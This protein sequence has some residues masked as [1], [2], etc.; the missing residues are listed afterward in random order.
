[1]SPLTGLVDESQIKPSDTKLVQGGKSKRAGLIVSTGTE[2]SLKH[3]RE[4]QSSW[5]NM[6]KT[7]N[8][9]F[10]VDSITLM[11]KRQFAELVLIDDF[12]AFQAQKLDVAIVVDVYVKEAI[13][14]VVDLRVLLFD[15]GIRLIG[16]ARGTAQ[17][18]YLTS[19]VPPGGSG[20]VAVQ[21]LRKAALASLDDDLG[22]LFDRGGR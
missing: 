16:E 3:V 11:L 18:N 20:D 19:P 12:R 10:L 13:A 22:R 14:S 15:Q 8:P 21:E 9:Q 4:M 5:F 6:P 1:M 7:L 2:S 17:R